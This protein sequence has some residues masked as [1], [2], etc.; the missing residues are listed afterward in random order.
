MALVSP[1]V[2]VTVIDESQYIPSAVNT[3]P[4]FVIATAQN[5]VSSDGITVAAGTLA[6]NANKTY[7]ITS[8][9]DLAATF[10]VP[11]FY[12]TTT[13]TPINGYELNEYGLLAAYSALGVTNRAYIQR[14]DV[15]LTALTASLTRPTGDPANGTYWLDAGISTWGIFE[16]NQTTAT[17]TNNIPTVITSTADV[18]GGDGTN[19]IADNTP[20]ASFG[21]IGDYAVVAIDPYVYGYYKTY[22]NVWVQ[23]GSNGWK[24]AWP[25]LVGANAPTTLTVGANMFINDNLVTVGATNTVAGLVSV[26]N[27]AAITGV[28]ARNVSNQLYLYAD[29]TAA[30]DGSTLGNN[31]LITIDTGTVSGAALLTALGITTGEYAA[32]DYLPA[33]SYQQPRWRTTDTDGGRPTGSVWQNISSANNGMNL[34]VKS[35]STALAVFVS[36]NCPV[37]AG[38]STALFGLDPSGGGRNIPVGTTYAVYDSDFYSTTPLN[39]FSFELL[40]RYATGALEVTGTTTPTGLAFTVGNSFTIVATEAGTTTTNTGLV[41]IGG[42]GTVSNFIAAVSA[43]GVPFVSAS[44]NTAGN[45]VFTHSQGGSIAA[46]NVVGTP[47]TAAGF[48]LT[49]PKVRQNSSNASVIS[50]S[51]FVTSPLFTYTA[52]DTAPDQD[53]VT[54]RLWYYSSVSD[55]DIMIQDNG[56]WQGYQ[57]V[58][59]DVRGYDLTLCNA[60]GPIIS[61]SA[62]VTQTDTAESPLAYGDLWIDTSDLEN[63]PKLYRWQAVSGTDQWVE[64]DTTD[65][66]SQ[67]GILFADARWAPNGTTDCVADPFP[68]IVSLLTSNYLDVDAPDPALYPQ[69]MLLFNTR[70]SGYN[71]KSFQGNYFNTTSTAFAIDAYSATTAYVFNDF[72]NYD[73]AVYVCVLATTAGIAPTNGTYWDL[74]NTNTWLTASGNKTNG[75]MWSGRLAQ[76]QL[77]VEALKAGIDTSAAAREEQN[78]FN[79]ISTPAYPELT[80]NMIALSNERNNTLFVIGD[81]PMRLGPDGN[82]LVA[83]ATNNN[84]LGLVTEDGNA[85]TSNYAG[86]FYPSCRTTDLGGN[87]VVQ[88]P[89]HM[90]VRTILRSDAASYPW[91]APA[92][93]RRGVIDNASAIGYIN[94]ATGEFEQIGVSQSVRDILYERNINP[95]TFIPGVGI[96][97]FGNKTSTVTTTALDR[98]NVARLVAFLRG[99]LEEIGKLYLF[100]PNDQ[101]TRNEVTNTCNSLMI[102]LVAKRAIYDYLVVCDGSNN[103]PARIDRNELYVDIAIEPVKA[104]EFIYIP[105]RIKNTGEIAGGSGG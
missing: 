3:V 86:V 50:L 32:P 53:P 15:D 40:E 39:T 13:G 63:Y 37:Y 70:R 76:R 36:Q 26:I 56:I 93:T 78:Q 29:S 41:T 104:I 98:I 65:Q 82:S 11:F 33:Y 66:V 4:Y 103:T 96:T 94:A 73:N 57:N 23:V 21:S 87:S 62:P 80:G 89:S 28:T 74:L 7:L 34:S 51:N 79:L 2:E 71:V 20:V 52:S 35:Y 54:G 8:Q 58:T 85:A 75:S 91:F 95:I 45:I 60:T 102:D 83:F 55:A 42:T 49:T 12:N 84:G 44:V 90:M 59:N 27:A 72:V 64:V 77:V 17:F 105:L 43:A 101:I 92:G 22:Q 99:R 88:P 14:A 38:D 68:S 5:K 19:P 24:T 1:G 18:V 16:W 31:G 30:N 25:T 47:L 9:R 67:S 61:A 48:D 81:T 100:E 69:G 6:A 46:I 10:G 97:N